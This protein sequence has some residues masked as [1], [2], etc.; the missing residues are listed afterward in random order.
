MNE[1][2]F[3]NDNNS[4]IILPLNVGRAVRSKYK[5]TS[6]K[7]KQILEFLSKDWN[8]TRAAASVGVSREAVYQLI[9]RDPKFASAYNQI[10]E[11]YTDVIEHACL[12]V[13]SQPTREGFNDRKLWLQA[14]RDIY[15]PK[16]EIKV[17]HVV[18]AGNAIAQ[19]DNLLSKFSRKDREINAIKADYKVEDT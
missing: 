8:M 14:H 19:L 7:R 4:V 13:A 6:K 11:A 1:H 16:Q 5:L 17:T 18:D 9:N 3:N 10:K 2:S 15:G 12:S